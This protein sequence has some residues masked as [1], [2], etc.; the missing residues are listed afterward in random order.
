AAVLAPNDGIAQ[1]LWIERLR[2]PNQIDPSDRRFM[3]E[4]EAPMRRA[5][6]GHRGVGRLA[7][8]D[9][10]QPAPEQH[11]PPKYQL[12]RRFVAGVNVP[13]LLEALELALIEAE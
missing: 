8:R 10:G 7:L 5:A 4:L 12:F 2:S 3:V 1:Q 9:R 13:G 11:L 6:F